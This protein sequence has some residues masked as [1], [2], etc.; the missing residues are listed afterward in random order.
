MHTPNPFIP[1]FDELPKSLPIFPL[2]GAV[3]LPPSDL[4]LNIFEPRYLNLV[5]DAM[6][7]NQLIGMIQPSGDSDK[8]DLYNV[9]CAG[10]ITQYAEDPSGK[11]QIVL[12]GVCRFAVEQELDSLRGYRIV[13][14]NWSAFE[15]DYQE[16]NTVGDENQEFATTLGEPFKTALRRYLADNNIDADWDLL[17]KLSANTLLNN[18]F[19]QL[20]LSVENK[21]LLLETRTAAERLRAF[22]A[23]LNDEAQPRSGLQ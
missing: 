12:T 3:F 20:P 17:N 16:V 11:I 6:R 21:Q 5:R 8:P 22:T 23:I 18:V 14:P 10:R 4:P 1:T 13:V 15:H 19:S 9:G 7:S 2:A